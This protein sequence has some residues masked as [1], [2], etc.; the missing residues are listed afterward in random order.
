MTYLHFSFLLDCEFLIPNLLFLLDLLTLPFLFECRL[1]LFS[2]ILHLLQVVSV[3]LSSSFLCARQAL[4]IQAIRRWTSLCTSESC[5]DFFDYRLVFDDR[6]R[7]T[8]TTQ[9]TAPCNRSLGRCCHDITHLDIYG[10][11]SLLSRW[12]I[13]RPWTK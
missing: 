10:D 11:L 12:H 7:F 5:W 4:G 1:L 2:S 9:E 8:A 6:D 3:F 13:L